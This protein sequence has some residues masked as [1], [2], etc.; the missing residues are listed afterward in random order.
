M[1]NEKRMMREFRGRDSVGGI[2]LK[3]PDEQIVEFRRDRISR[4][5]VGIL[6]E[7]ELHERQRAHLGR[8]HG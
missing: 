8:I 1:G 2:A 7:D 3:R 6:M 4:R 5:H